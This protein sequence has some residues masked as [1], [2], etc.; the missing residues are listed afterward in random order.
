MVFVDYEFSIEFW[1]LC[2]N[3]FLFELFFFAYW[4]YF[5][6]S[7]L[8]MTLLGLLSNYCKCSALGDRL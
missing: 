2:Y 4:V 3:I 5:E 6:Y 8:S 7:I 1:L